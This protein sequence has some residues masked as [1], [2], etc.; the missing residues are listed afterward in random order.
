MIRYLRL[1]ALLAGVLPVLPAWAQDPV[2]SQFMTNKLY[3]NPAYIGFDEGMVVNSSWREQY[4]KIGG[5]QTKFTTR[6]IGASLAV[7][8]LQSGFMVQYFDHVEGAGNLQWQSVGIGYG[9]RNRQ[10]GQTAY[11]HERHELNLGLRGSYN[12]FG[13]NPAG[14]VFSDQLDAI[15]GAVL[16][17][18]IPPDMLAGFEDS[19]LDLDVGAML[20]SRLG[21]LRD[22]PWWQNGVTLSHVPRVDMAPRNTSDE[23]PFRL[24]Y[25][26]ALLKKTRFGI[27]HPQTMYIVPMYRLELQPATALR[28]TVD[29]NF[30]HSSHQLGLVFD[31]ESAPGIWGGIWYQ[32]GYNPL[33]ARNTNSLI[34]A[35]GVSA[36]IWQIGI[37]HDYNYSGLRSNSGGTWEFTLNLVFPGLRS[38]ECGY[39]TPHPRIKCPVF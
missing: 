7:P 30:W 27:N 37:S 21:T 10:C 18:G 15:F 9:W 32:G 25:H 17:Q 26:T 33:N 24:T 5:I 4:P 12:W 38:G 8:K 35:G 6:H 16:P 34:V 31:L 2:F 14:F 22:G 3:L 1:L 13:I 28:G 11:T 39:R 19:Y 23:K 29:G 20:E 36:D